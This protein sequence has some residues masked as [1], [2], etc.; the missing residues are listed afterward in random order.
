M[1]YISR[2]I[3]ESQYDPS[4]V[5][6]LFVTWWVMKYFPIKIFQNKAI[7][8]HTNLNSIVYKKFQNHKKRQFVGTIK[9][10]S[11]GMDWWVLHLVPILSIGHNLISP[12]LTQVKSSWDIFSY[13]CKVLSSHSLY[14]YTWPRRCPHAV[15]GL[16]TKDWPIDRVYEPD[17]CTDLFIPG[18]CCE[19]K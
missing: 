17:H 12:L 8:A 13:V 6:L 19:T 18:T 2:N 7:V 5:L 10:I 14:R 16:H 3:S 11:T 4:F 1:S 15:V 9:W